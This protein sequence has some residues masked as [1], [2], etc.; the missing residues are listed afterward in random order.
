MASVARG[1]H[2]QRKTGEQQEKE[3]ET[4][5]MNIAFH[6]CFL[7]VLKC[8]FLIAK[9]NEALKVQRQRQILL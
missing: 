4:L 7:N 9:S 3:R 1:L 8:F 6:G 2:I 5:F